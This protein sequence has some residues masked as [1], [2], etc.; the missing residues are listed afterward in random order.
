M[1]GTRAPLP[2]EGA[3]TRAQNGWSVRLRVRAEEIT[4]AKQTVIGERVRL[5]RT[6]VQEVARVDAVLRREQL[7]RTK[8]GPVEVREEVTE[9]TS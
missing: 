9:K 8:S 4:I 7:R 1:T 5:Q 2:I 3:P 6:R